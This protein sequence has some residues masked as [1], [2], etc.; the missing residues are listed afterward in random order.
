M[1]QDV[2]AAGRRV[3]VLDG[4]GL[5]VALVCGRFNDHVTNRLV[6]GAH[7]GLAAA[8]VAEGDVCRDLGARRL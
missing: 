8:G 6:A 2:V 3:P 4:S 1:A 7:R 5:R